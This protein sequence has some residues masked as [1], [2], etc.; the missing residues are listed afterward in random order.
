MVGGWGS[1]LWVNR[2]LS[3][4]PDGYGPKRKKV[5]FY[6]LFLKICL[7]INWRIIALQNFV[8]FCQ[9]S[10]WISHQIRSDQS[11]SRVQ[12]FATPW[13]AARQ[14]SLS[15]TNSIS[16]PSWTSLPSPSPSHPSRLVQS[17]CLSCLRHTA[18]KFI[19][20]IWY[21]KIQR[22]IWSRRLK[23]LNVCL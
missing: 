9:T 6:I 20:L 11:L 13:I 21:F 4:T 5:K 7:C 8:A 14:A 15:I 19:F 10:T 1:R 23:F 12:L 2:F 3:T 18:I 16:P 22:Q 17:P